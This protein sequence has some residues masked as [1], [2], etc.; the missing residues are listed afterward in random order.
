MRI[1]L[2]GFGGVGKA[3]V[4]LISDKRKHLEGLGLNISLNCVINSTGGV[5][6]PSGID[7]EDLLRHTASGGRLYDYPIGGSPS[8]NFDYLVE[9]GQADLIIEATPTNKETGEPGMTHIRKALE[10]GMHVVTAN[11]GPILLA[12]KEL[13]NIAA[14][15]GV[16]LFA[17]CTTGGALPAINAGLYDLAGAEILSIEGILNGTT[18]FI[19]DR[20]EKA[21]ICYKEALNDAQ[22]LGIA[23][24]DPTLDVE[25]WDTATKLAILTNVLMDHQINLKDM[26]VEGITAITADDIKIA[27]RQQKRYKLIGRVTMQDGHIEAIVKPQAISSN[28]PLYGIGQ[29]NKAVT[30]TTDT[31][32][33]ITVAGGASGTISAAASLLR[34]IVNLHKWGQA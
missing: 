22:R 9:H 32:G 28:H 31:L 34:D 20:M 30:Y 1:A 13:N 16:R 12:Y 23:E 24:T 3:F 25:G 11:K 15:S 27:S 7:C 26:Y 19:L 2:V 21:G 18:N 6:N 10:S 29:A 33:T 14:R 4:R 5:Y 17:G 8:I